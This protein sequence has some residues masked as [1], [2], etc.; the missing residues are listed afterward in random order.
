MFL[1]SSIVINY[2]EQQ[3][4]DQAALAWIYCDYNEQQKQDASSLISSILR[5]I[6][7]KDSDLTGEIRDLYATGKGRPSLADFSRLLGLQ[8]QRFSK[9]FIVID[10]LDECVDE[11]IREELVEALRLP[12]VHLLVTSRRLPSIGALFA[13]AP[14]LEIKARDLDIKNY[15]NDRILNE[16][17]LVRLVKTDVSLKTTIM[18]TVTEKAQGM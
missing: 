2:L 13:D 18:S 10:A 16:K 11:D 8:T 5:Q 9:V 17:R 3:L 14:H 4:R 15:L 7:Q 1:R 6:F 12:S